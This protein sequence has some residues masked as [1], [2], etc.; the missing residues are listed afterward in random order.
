MKKES[1]YVLGVGVLAFAVGYY[2]TRPKN[3][4]DIESTSSFAGTTKVPC[5]TREQLACLT[6]DSSK[7]QMYDMLK[8]CGLSD[9]QIKA[10]FQATKK[11]IEKNLCK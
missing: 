3:N 9:E 6:S 5:I 10:Y 11:M 2:L 1:L 4:V 8:K 7:R